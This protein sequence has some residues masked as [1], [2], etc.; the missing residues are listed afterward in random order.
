MN[1]QPENQKPVYVAGQ[2]SPE[3]EGAASI[4]MWLEIVFGIF[5]ILGI[6]HVYSG[7]IALGI[8]LMF[9]WWAFI[10]IAAFIISITFGLGAC[11]FVPLFLVVPIISGIQARTYIQRTGGSGSWQSV[12]LATGG[13]CLL[14][15]VAMIVLS[16]FGILVE[17]LP[18]I[19]M[20]QNATSTPIN[21][22]QPVSTRISTSTAKPATNVTPANE[23]TF[24]NFQNDM[25]LIPAGEFTIGVNGEATSSQQINLP[26]YYI[27]KFET[28]NSIYEECVSDGV[29]A[30]PTRLDSSSNS[31]YFGNPQFASYPVI[32]VTWDMAETF[33]RWRDARLPTEAEWEKAAR[34]VDGRIYPW[35]NDFTAG[36]SNF[37][38]VNCPREWRDINYNDGYAETSPVGVF[39]SGQSPYGIFDMSGNVYE[40]VADSFYPTTT[41]DKVIRGGA[42]SD[43]ES[44]NSTS[45]ATFSPS[46]AYE[47]IGFRCARDDKP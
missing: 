35:G 15:I 3:T 39:P 40:W 38:D 29:C 7:R 24:S 25:I 16:A 44:V 2:S 31:F 28:T 30:S 1:H 17:T 43:I 26:N 5:S 20:P 6:G 47:F 37:C 18:E 22:V 23:D 45:R 21:T 8:A 36:A 11:I 4:A 19:E 34:G 33:C 32:Y 27:D 13:G 41:Q 12:G 10:A 46:S 42:W 9:G 14:I